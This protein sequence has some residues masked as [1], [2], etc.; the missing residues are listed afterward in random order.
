MR[1][2]TEVVD[3]VTPADVEHGTSR[4]DGAESDV[5]AL[6]PVEDGSLQRAALAEKC[7]AA[8]AGHGF[9]EGRIQPDGGIHETHAV[10]SNQAKRS[11][12]QMFLNFFFRSEERRVGKECRSRWS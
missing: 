7:D 6:A 1:I 12:Q 11:A 10:R 4:D 5:F 8:F 3:Q 9:G 2:F